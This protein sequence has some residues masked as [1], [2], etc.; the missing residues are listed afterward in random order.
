MICYRYNTYE[1]DRMIIN[2][3]KI[4]SA[5]F[6]QEKVHGYTV[7][8]RKWADGIYTVFVFTADW[9]GNQDVLLDG[10]DVQWESHP[11]ETE[12]VYAIEEALENAY[13]RA[14]P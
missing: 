12:I 3:E 2:K 7:L 10:A 13:D 6:L 8:L 4:I 11:T 14:H 1:R 5:E 9:A